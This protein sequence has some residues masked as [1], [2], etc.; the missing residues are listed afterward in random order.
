MS[1]RSRIIRLLIDAAIINLG[2]IV[3]YLMR[4]NW[5]LF[6]EIGFDAHLN[7]YVPVLLAFSLAFLAMFYIDGVY[8]PRRAPSWFD[9]MNV[10]SLWASNSCSSTSA[11]RLYMVTSS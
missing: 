6:R 1:T 3:G 2:F 4:Y 8:T 7:D 9:Q 11:S 5:R 10:H